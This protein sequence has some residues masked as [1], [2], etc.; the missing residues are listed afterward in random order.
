MKYRTNKKDFD[1]FKKE[2]IK[3]IP[4]LGLSNWRIEVEHLDAEDSGRAQYE[5]LVN[6]MV[7]T[8]KLGIDWQDDKKS[9]IR[10]KRLAFHELVHVR[11]AR[12]EGM[13]AARGY[14]DEEISNALHEV[15]YT[16]EN[17]HMIKDKSKYE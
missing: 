17:L 13:L 16:F 7:A 15:I 10:I 1:L 5:I 14:S 2:A 8:I 9:N 11:L 4:Q 12:I 3:W 6:E